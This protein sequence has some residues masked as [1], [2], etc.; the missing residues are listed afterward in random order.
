MTPPVHVSLLWDRLA[1]AEGLPGWA[2][3]PAAEVSAAVV[4]LARFTVDELSEGLW[5]YV[6][7]AKSARAP[8]TRALQFCARRALDSSVGSSRV[9]GPVGWA[10]F[11]ERQG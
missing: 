10:R 2:T 6:D 1:V 5:H 8:A 9:P 4:R 7:P 11:M 3:Y